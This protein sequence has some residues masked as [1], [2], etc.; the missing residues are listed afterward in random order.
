MFGGIVHR[1]LYGRKWL[2]PLY[3][4]AHFMSLFG[5]NYG[6]AVNVA[7]SGE[8]VAMAN[9][10]QY[11]RATPKLVIFD[12]GANQGE[13]CLHAIQQ[14]GK[15]FPCWE[16]HAFEPS[17]KNF[18]G[19]NIAVQHANVKTYQL[20][21]SDIKGVSAFFEYD[22]HT[23]SS[24][25]NTSGLYGGLDGGRITE[26]VLETLDDFI[27]ANGI[28]FIHYLKMD[29]EGHELAVLNGAANALK[30]NRIGI[31]QF[32]FGAANIASKTFLYEFFRL[33]SGYH[34]HR[35]LQDGLSGRL[36]YNTRL[37]IFQTANYLAIPK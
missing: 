15:A 7:S 11:F 24:L 27:E 35:I 37:E 2:Q 14:I 13:F 6:R 29:V 8:L 26:V 3:E 16:L 19:L 30:K 21:L 31:I 23:L 28:D 22:I 33:L 10:C 5:M 32:E 9:V 18:E 36:E 17:L 20:G 4:K 1:Y 34:I 25:Y 12:V